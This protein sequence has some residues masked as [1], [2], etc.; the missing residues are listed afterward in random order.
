MFDYRLKE[1]IR[2][3]LFNWY[4]TH[5]E[6]ESKIFDFQIVRKIWAWKK[7]LNCKGQKLLQIDFSQQIFSAKKSIL[8]VLQSQSIADCVFSRVLLFQK[9]FCVCCASVAVLESWD[10]KCIGGL[11]NSSM[12]ASYNKALARNCLFLPLRAIGCEER[13]FLPAALTW[14]V[15]NLIAVWAARTDRLLSELQQQ[16][17]R[18]PQ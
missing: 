3:C 2:F 8:L 10:G 6:V 7:C 14:G 1:S 16:L 12:A 11:C 4:V 9:S 17:P 15:E 18:Q 13:R 5:K